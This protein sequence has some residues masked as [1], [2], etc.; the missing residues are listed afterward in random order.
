M[1]VS[2]DINNIYKELC[3][4]L[5]SSNS[6]NKNTIDLDNVIFTLTDINNNIAGIRNISLEYLCG[7]MLWYICGRNDIDF[8]HKFSTFWSR[9][10]D[11]G[12]TCNS[13]YGDILFKRHGFNQVEKI[14]E[15]LKN[16]KDSRRAVLN[17]NVPNKNVIETNDEI[18]TI[19]LVLKVKDNR[20]DCTGIMRSNDIYLGLPY[21]VAF[22]T[23]IQKYIANKL[24]LKYGK[25]T[26]FVTNLHLYN[27][28]IENIN[29]VLLKDYW[30]N[31]KFDYEKM[32]L[33]SNYLESLTVN[34]EH[35]KETLLR[36]CLDLKI[37]EVKE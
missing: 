9:L 5:L 14:I 24:S 37:L 6:V 10:S 20:L 30:P 36:H 29:E 32:M 1:I 23:S 11:D 19:A 17:F 28:D 12:I 31:I 26:H 7:E 21:D 15:L 33:Y 35:P 2:N 34:S 18:C 13:A 25:Y 27:R 22:F 16:D 4:K 8:I 3:K